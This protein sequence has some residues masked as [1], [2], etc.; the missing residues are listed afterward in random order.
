MKKTI[1]IDWGE[2]I[3]EVSKK[4]KEFK[5]TSFYM[6]STDLYKIDN[7]KLTQIITNKFEK[8]HATIMILIDT[9]DKQLIAKKINFGI[10]SLKYII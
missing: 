9:K 4:I 1:N 6:L 5:I 3:S 10:S 7:K 2:K 8:H